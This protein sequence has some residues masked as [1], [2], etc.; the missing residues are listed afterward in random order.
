MSFH[1][2]KNN[3]LLNRDTSHFERP[4][5]RHRPLPKTTTRDAHSHPRSSN[6]K[7]QLYLKPN[8]DEDFTFELDHDTNESNINARS[9]SS[10]KSESTIVWNRN[11]NKSID[12]QRQ[13]LPIWKHKREILYAISKYNATI[14]IGET[15]SGKT[16]Q[17][18]QYC[19]HAGYCQNGRMIC[20]TQPRRIAAVRVA[21]RV[22]QEMKCDNLG[23]LVGYAIRLNQK[24]SD[25]T[26]I[27]FVTDGMLLC[28]FFLL[29]FLL[30]FFDYVVF[31]VLFCFLNILART[32]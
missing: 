21:Q 31:F 8:L 2:S 20:C 18:S 3:F 12:M 5:K 4:Y 19:Y 23:D 13:L 1:N 25:K 7:S 16:T 30:F 28:M 9:S 26:R 11:I 24:V 27:K 10:N 6:T 32:E 15:G 29:F 14:I 17:V 22:A